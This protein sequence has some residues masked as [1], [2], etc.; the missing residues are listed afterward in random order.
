MSE[1]EREKVLTKKKLY[2]YGDVSRMDMKRLSEDIRRCR[3][4]GFAQDIGEVTPGV[5]VISAPVFDL[6][7]K[8]VGCTILIGTFAA[9]KTQE[10][11]PR[12]ASVSRQISHRLGARTGLYSM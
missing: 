7:E 5:I 12:V 6:R 9:S 11:G 4:L 3:D 10:Y 8:I 1:P 2:F